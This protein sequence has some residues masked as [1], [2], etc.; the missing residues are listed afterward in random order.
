MSRRTVKVSIF[1]YA[2]QEYRSE[3]MQVQKTN[4]IV[5]LLVIRKV[6]RKLR[7]V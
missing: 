2:T 5:K 6:L 1:L 4:L 7:K 3:M